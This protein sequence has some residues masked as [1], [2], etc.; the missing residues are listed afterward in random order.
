MLL[1]PL[2]VSGEK[3]ARHAHKELAQ[4]GFEFLLDLGAG[5]GLAG[6]R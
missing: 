2:V 5:G 1:R 3:Q 6:L 4:D